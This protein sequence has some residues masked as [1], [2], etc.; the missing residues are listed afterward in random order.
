MRAEGAFEG[1]KKGLGSARPKKGPKWTVLQLKLLGKIQPRFFRKF[2]I[3][4]GGVVGS[5]L[6]VFGNGNCLG[7]LRVRVVLLAVVVVSVVVV[8][9]VVSGWVCGGWG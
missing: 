8:L 2:G 6:D 1:P 4:V 9:V 7:M 5:V 3:F